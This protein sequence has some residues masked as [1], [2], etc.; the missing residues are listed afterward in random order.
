VGFSCLLFRMG[1]PAIFRRRFSRALEAGAITTVLCGALLAQT[2][3]APMTVESVEPQSWRA[4]PT[5]EV[6][7]RL[8]GQ[9]LDS[10]V[11]VKIKHKGIRV[12]RMGSPDPNHLFVLLLISSNAEPGTVI[13]QVST[14]F[15]T[16][17]AALPMFEQGSES[18]L[19]GEPASGAA[20]GL[21]KRSSAAQ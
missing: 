14:H 6:M 16:T 3:S 2:H 20:D 9:Q 13:L 1:I 17:F 12:I 10:V 4:G 7:V 18:S 19:R 8:S 5:A 15:M 11:G 21:S